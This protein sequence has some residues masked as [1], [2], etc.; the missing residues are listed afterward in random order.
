MY[1]KSRIAVLVAAIVFGT[2]VGVAAM[3]ENAATDAGRRSEALSAEPVAKGE[4][5]TIA[6]A[7]TTAPR[8]AEASPG[9]VE[10]TT[11]TMRGWYDRA[12]LAFRNSTPPPTFPTS[13]DAEVEMP[14]MPTQV[15]YFERLEQQRLARVQPAQEAGIASASAPAG[16]S[17]LLMAHEAAR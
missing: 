9:I 6:S 1:T 14:L 7:D 15:A 16:T 17:E 13:Y 5:V 10:K 2:Q 12:A 4:P 8:K 11:A 3:E